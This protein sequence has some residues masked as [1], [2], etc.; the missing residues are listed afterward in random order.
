MTSDKAIDDNSK[1]AVDIA[2]EV[3]RDVITPPTKPCTSLRS[4]CR[5]T[6]STKSLRAFRHA[7]DFISSSCDK[8]PRKSGASLKWGSHKELNKQG[9]NPRQRVFAIQDKL[10]AQEKLIGYGG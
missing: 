2:K 6:S 8:N 3:R 10:E 4:F 9:N 1:M 5:N 7:A